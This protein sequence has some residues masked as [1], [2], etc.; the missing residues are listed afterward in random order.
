MKRYS[1]E[2]QKALC[3]LCNQ[4]ILHLRY[5]GNAIQSVF[6][7]AEKCALLMEQDSRKALLFFPTDSKKEENCRTFAQ[8]VSLLSLIE[9]AEKNR[10]IYLQPLETAGDIFFYENFD[11]SFFYGVQQ[12]ENVK[13]NISQREKIVYDIRN[14][15]LLY[16]ELDGKRIMESMDVSNLYDLIKKLLCS[17]GFPT[18]ALAR[19]I[20]NGYCFD[21]E[22]RSIWSLRFSIASFFSAMLALIVS[23][24]CI[25]VWYSN[26]HGYTTIDTIQYRQLVNSIHT[27]QLNGKQNEVI[28]TLDQDKY[29][30]EK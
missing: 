9:H 22:K 30:K 21:E 11:G 6:F 27:L 13:H 15:N 1:H 3:L 18:S 7:K 2:E 4:D 14:H 12:N 28:D 25:S 20:N 17:R 16:I 26:K 23:M 19:F 29:H 5:V 10:L 8:F 24:P